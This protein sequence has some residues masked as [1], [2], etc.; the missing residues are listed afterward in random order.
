MRKQLVIIGLLLLH[1]NGIMAQNSSSVLRISSFRE[2]WEYALKN[3]P[4]QKSYA[5]NIEKAKSELK[6][7]KSFLWPS[8]AGSANAQHNIDLPETP[9]PGEL[10]GKPGQT[11]YAKFGK[12]NSFNAGLSLSK[13]ILDWQAIMQMKLSENSVLGEQLQSDAFRQSLKQ[14]VALYYYTAA[15]SQQALRSSQQDLAVAD[16]VITLTRQKSEQGLINS[17][18]ANQSVINRNNIRQQVMNTESLLEQCRVSLKILFGADKNTVLQLIDPDYEDKGVAN[19][20]QSLN[21]DRQ[22]LVQENQLKSTDYKMRIQKSNFLPRLSLNTYLGQQQYNDNLSVSFAN[23]AWKPVS[24][25]ALTLQVPVFTGFATKNKLKTAKIE[26]T[27][28]QNDWE[29]SQRKAALKDNLLLFEFKKSSEIVQTNLDSYHLY[30]Q[31]RQLAGQQLKE[32]VIGLDDYFRIFEDYLKAESS[33]LN[34]LSEMYTSYS[35]IISRQ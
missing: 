27:I 32:G 1:S 3:N 13:S 15:V 34:A 10:V 14:Q 25:M 20:A 5:L 35:T 31:N 12:K 17:I 8:I 9:V 6:T 33:Y 24:Y 21:V 16:S 26:Y 22:L 19:P 4:D 28:A 11:F 2:A 30:G 29:E 18:T 23:G 7:S